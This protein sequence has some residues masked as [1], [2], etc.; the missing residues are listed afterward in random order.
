MLQCDWSAVV[1]SSQLPPSEQYKN[2]WISKFKCCN[3]IGQQWYTPHNCHLVSNTITIEFQ[4]SNAAMWLVS[5]VIQGPLNFKI[6]MLQCDWSAVVY[7]SDLPPSEQYKNHWISKFKCCN[8][9][10]QQWYS[11]HNSHLVSNTRTIE[12]QNS[13]AAMWLVSSGILLTTAT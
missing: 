1:Y 11:P 3:V 12:F 7:S 5:W 10:G 9:I 6:T 13:N 4:N 2:H 8:V